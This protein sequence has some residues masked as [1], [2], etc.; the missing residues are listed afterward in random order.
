MGNGYITKE[1]KDGKKKVYTVERYRLITAI[2]TIAVIT[3]AIIVAILFC[4]AAFN[5]Y[6]TPDVLSVTGIVTS[7][8][9]VIAFGTYLLLEK[10]SG[11]KIRKE[12]GKKK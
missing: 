12:N 5:E 8:V 3:A 7:A 4:G 10:P 9:V 11:P 2:K 1:R 6:G